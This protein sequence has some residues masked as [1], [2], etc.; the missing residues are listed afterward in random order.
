MLSKMFLP[1]HRGQ[2]R[3]GTRNDGSGLGL[4]IAHRAVA[5][6]GGKIGAMNAA[7]GGLIVDIEIPFNP[8]N[9]RRAEAFS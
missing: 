1:F 6:N 4:A 2:T 5:A 9:S 7:D 3:D 8:E